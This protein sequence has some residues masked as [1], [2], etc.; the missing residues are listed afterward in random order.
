MKALRSEKTRHKVMTV[1]SE[2][3]MNGRIDFDDMVDLI[4]VDNA[5]KI[6]AVVEGAERSMKEATNA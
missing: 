4:G 1:V 3:Y 6:R 2:A 5:K